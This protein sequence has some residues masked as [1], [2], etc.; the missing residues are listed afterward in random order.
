[1]TT[2]RRALPF[3]AIVACGLA[4]AEE[5]PKDSILHAPRT[6]ETAARVADLLGSPDVEVRK[7]AARAL[8][9]FGAAVEPV[10]P[11]LVD[12]ALSD[13]PAADSAIGALVETAPWVLQHPDAEL[14]A[15]RRS[16]RR[17]SAFDVLRVAL[18]VADVRAR[19]RVYDLSR[20]PG[21]FRTAALGALHG[22]RTAS[23]LEFSP[24]PLPLDDPD[25][26]VRVEAASRVVTYS[27][28]IERAVPI[29]LQGI[30]EGDADTRRVALER[31]GIVGMY[32][33]DHLDRVAALAQDDDPDVRAMAARVFVEAVPY[34]KAWLPALGTFAKDPVAFVRWEALEAIARLGSNHPDVP[35]ALHGFADDP[36]EQ[37]R[38]RLLDLVALRGARAAEHAVTVRAALRDPSDRVRRRAVALAERLDTSSAEWLEPLEAM[39][40]DEPVEELRGSAL[41]LLAEHPDF[42]PGRHVARLSDLVAGHGAAGRGLLRAGEEGLR[43]LVAQASDDAHFA[44]R[45][46]A[47]WLSTAPADVRARPDVRAVLLRAHVRRDALEGGEWTLDLAQ[48][49][50][51]LES[52]LDETW[53]E[54]ERW[55]AVGFLLRAGRSGVHVLL[56]RALDPD[57]PDLFCAEALARAPL[58]LVWPRLA[59]RLRD[60]SPYVR[61]AVATALDRDDLPPRVR[62]RFAEMLDDPFWRVRLQVVRTLSRVRPLR[63]VESV[64]RLLDDRRAEVREAAREAVERSER[65]K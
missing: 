21:P 52:L 55:S 60:A 48:D 4:R 26:R 50:P 20:A 59:S 40:E 54:Y 9:R 17:S 42:D 22:R 64:Q 33:K 23:E 2:L 29:L 57:A 58:P 61:L 16:P 65:A 39:L 24:D 35:V 51:V 7:A 11:A 37:V 19:R 8:A 12:L 18:G 1:V 38:I 3:V 6:R 27:D 28:S 5:P 14:S 62:K 43:A 56:D 53:G 32:A 31:L 46:A 15:I 49:F 41:E 44:T 30:E 10:L 25:L 34:S 36:D 63:E 13:D 45:S 47:Y